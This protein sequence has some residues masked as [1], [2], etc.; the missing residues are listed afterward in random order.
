[1]GCGCEPQQ[2]STRLSP[3]DQL[4]A[5]LAEYQIDWKRYR[6]TLWFAFWLF[7]RII[8]WEVVLRRALGDRP[9][10]LGRTARMHG[11]ARRFRKLAI[12]MGGVMIKLGQFVSS[13]V[14]LLPA[15][16]TAELASLQDEVPSVPFDQI[17]QTLI[18]DLGDVDQHFVAFN[19]TPLAAASFGQA[20]RA[21]LHN[22]EC[23]VVKI[24]R[25]GIRNLVHTDLTALGVVARWLMKL[26]LISRRANLPALLEEFS[27]GLWDELNYVEE[28]NHAERFGT[29]FNADMGIYIPRLYREH[30]TRRVLTLEDVTAIKIT[31]YDHME[32]AGINRQD[33]ARR[34]MQTYLHMIFDERFFHADPHPGNLF[35]YALPPGSAQPP[36]TDL[37]GAPFYLIFVDFGMVGRLTPKTVAGLRETLIALTTHDARRLVHAY[38]RL[39]ILLPGADIDRIEM[40][41]RAAFERVWGLNLSELTKMQFSEMAV[42]GHE[43]NDLLFNMPFQVPQDF[44]YL[45]RAAGILIGMVTGL[46]PELDP[47]QEIQPFVKTLLSGPGAIQAMRA[48]PLSFNPREMMRGETLAALFS[49][50]GRDL[51]LD[52]SS[53]MARRVMQ[54]PFVFDDVLRRADRGDLMVRVSPTPELD[55]QIRRLEGV[56]Q[57]VVSAVMFAGLAFSSTILYAVGA[58]N[59]AFIGF[60]LTGIT[61]FRVV[62]AVNATR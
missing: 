35:V 25:P 52:A 37:H 40:A 49:K 31:D 62:L 33:V 6:R 44:L 11:W 41:T 54:L 1:M 56:A 20:H 22:G 14:D 48:A 47:W 38:K 32:E 8:F 17:R 5:E 16:V 21:K 51:V 36:N 57:R 53:D 19:P 12:E 18:E 24:Q 42:L 10:S 50:E 34:L 43:F 3:A 30:S 29:M 59:L 4:S 26:P 28:A 2:P 55:R 9:I 46:D 61:F 13:R 58:H 7:A 39:G 45:A 60:V 27:A 23:S 15:V